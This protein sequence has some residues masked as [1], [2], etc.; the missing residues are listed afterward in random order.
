MSWRD[1]SFAEPVRYA[2]EHAEETR[3]LL[4]LG[5]AGPTPS[6]VLVFHGMGQQ[7]R[8]QTLSDL[9][10]AILDEAESRGGKAT[11]LHIGLAPKASAPGQ[12]LAR[13]EI[14]PIGRIGPIGQLAEPSGRADQIVFAGVLDAAAG[15]VFGNAGFEEIFLFFKVNDFAHPG[16]RI[17]AFILL[18]QAKLFQTAI[19][20]V[21][22]VFTQHRHIQ[23]QN[24]VGKT[25]L[26]II[27]F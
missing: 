7:V 20:Y 8:F 2:P 23:S 12:F 22:H 25:F 26:G 15:L 13:A 9:A 14:G 27:A 11:D 5:A 17:S 18:G 19:S 16:K 10:S 1:R 6:A 21:L 24:P 4:E 3:G